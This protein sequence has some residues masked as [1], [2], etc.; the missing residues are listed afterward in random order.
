[1][2]QRGEVI[3]SAQVAAERHA[4]TGHVG[5]LLRDRLGGV[6]QVVP[7][8]GVGI[9][10]PQLLGDVHAHQQKMRLMM[11]G[12]D[13]LLALPGTPVFPF[14]AVDEAARPILSTRSSTGSKHSLGHQL[15]GNRRFDADQRRRPAR[16]EIRH[17]LD[18]DAVPRNRLDL[19][20][21]AGRVLLRPFVHRRD[22]DAAI[23]SG[24]A[25]DA[26]RARL[27]RFVRNA[28]AVLNNDGALMPIAAAPLT[29]VRRL[30]DNSVLD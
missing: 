19:E 7:V 21:E 24:L 2:Q 6:Q 4:E 29:N 25:P 18:V 16:G 5:L 17:Q 27:S 9:L 8:P 20:F 28:L 15:H 30:S 1:M 23:G 12:N 13:V 3:V 11:G 14:H 26:R 10:E 22:S